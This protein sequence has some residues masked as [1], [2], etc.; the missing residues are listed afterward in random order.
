MA[1]LKWFA[2][3]VGIVIG[4]YLG[5]VFLFA[6][7]FA[8]ASYLPLLARKIRRLFGARRGRTA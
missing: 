5:I 4:A 7:Y 1:A 2:W 6:A 8:L 3:G